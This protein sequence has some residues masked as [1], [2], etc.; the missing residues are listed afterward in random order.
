MTRTLAPAAIVTHDMTG[1]LALRCAVGALVADLTVFWTLHAAGFG[2]D[3]AQMISLAAAAAIGCGLNAGRLAPFTRDVDGRQWLIMAVVTALLVLFLRSGL[4]AVLSVR[5]GWWPGL[6]IIP[7][8][9]LSA[10]L[11]A[12]SLRLCVLSD[13]AGDRA[14]PPC[15]TW[16]TG[17]AIGYLVLLRFFY[18]ALPEILHEEGYYWNYAAHLDLGYLDHPPL[19]G[20]V[21]WACT[22][23]LG[24][25]EFAVRL[26]PFLLWFAGAFFIHRLTRS[27]YDRGTALDAVL[28]YA[29]L[30]YFFGVSF[31]MLPDSCL[32]PCWA[33]ALYFFH[34]LLVDERRWAW[35]GLGISVGLGMLSKYTMILPCLGGLLFVLIDGRARRLL[36]R[37]GPWLALGLAVVIFSPVILWNA[38]HGWASFD[39]QGAARARREF[40]FDLPDLFGAVCLLI[41][42][43]GVLAV[44]TIAATRWRFVPPE[45]GEPRERALRLFKLMM[46]LTAVPLAVFVV[47]SLFRGTRLIWTGPLWLGLIPY[48]AWMMAPG[49][50]RHNRGFP[51]FGRGL[52]LTLVAVLALIYG[53]SLRL[54]VLGLPGAPTPVDVV[55]EGWSQIAAQ[56]EALADGIERESG[57][58]PLPVGMDTDRVAS[59][60]AFYG[61]RHREDHEVGGRH[62][63]GLDSG[64]Y[65][66]WMEPYEAARRTLI[67]V[68][69]DRDALEGPIVESRVTDCG[70]IGELTAVRD[71]RTIRRVFYRIVQGYDGLGRAGLSEG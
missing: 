35:V 13:A 30:P 12:L 71:G 67:L 34:R 42:P 50:E 63:F 4:M 70:E 62:L 60:L 48:L 3:M 69:Q 66:L 27:I 19:V 29:A 8:A 56:V 28:L 1:Q 47:A 37:P 55:G 14:A 36:L 52:W 26:G 2:W 54:V 45:E 51:V 61:P 31:F 44:I 21:I 24:D 38:Q 39:F 64:M 33:A 57:R 40:D 59:W 53:G 41:T 23:V 20:W 7:P 15:R 5:A 6:A 68:A 11:A 9:L 49:M 17:A 18:L 46:C 22:T 58:R 65:E 10:F 43:L 16:L 25:T 32:V